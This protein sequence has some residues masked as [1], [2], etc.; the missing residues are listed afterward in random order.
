MIGFDLKEISWKYA[1][2][3]YLSK[4]KLDF[5]TKLK[6]CDI[7]SF[8]VLRYLIPMI[9]IPVETVNYDSFKLEFLNNRLVLDTF[10]NGKYFYD[11]DRLVKIDYGKDLVEYSYSQNQICKYFNRVIEEVNQYDEQGRIIKHSGGYIHHEFV[12][13][14]S[15]TVIYRNGHKFASILYAE[16]GFITDVYFSNSSLHYEYKNEDMFSCTCVELASETR[17]TDIIFPLDLAI[18]HA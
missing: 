18:I 6:V 11:N 9:C 10:F 5:P 8:N 14:S 3:L 7:H 4:Q 12:Y 13:G 2:A 17:R 1:R 16:D 15:E